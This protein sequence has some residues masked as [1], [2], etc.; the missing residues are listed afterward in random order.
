MGLSVQKQTM[1]NRV[2]A[3]NES[4]SQT[5]VTCSTKSI[6]MTTCIYAINPKQ[7]SNHFTELSL[8]IGKKSYP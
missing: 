3:L 8:G 2:L 1:K 7:L 4:Q 6:F 5:S